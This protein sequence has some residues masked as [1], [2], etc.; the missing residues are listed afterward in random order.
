M[1]S[2]K[3][4][5]AYKLKPEIVNLIL[6]YAEKYHTSKTYIVECALIDFFKSKNEDVL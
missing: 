5:Q 2:K 6:K 3:I 4:L 1:N